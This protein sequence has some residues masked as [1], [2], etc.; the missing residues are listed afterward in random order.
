MIDK[1]DQESEEYLKWRQGS[2][3][4][5]E[6]Q[7]VIEPEQVVEELPEPKR[8]KIF[9]MDWFFGVETHMGQMKMMY[10]SFT[11]FFY[12]LFC[13]FMAYAIER[14][15]KPEFNILEI[16]YLFLLAIPVAIMLPF[17]LL[18]M[19]FTLSGG[20]FIGMFV[21]I[22]S[23]LFGIGGK[24]LYRMFGFD[25]HLL[26]PEFV[27]KKGE[28]TKRSILGKR[29]AYPFTA[30]IRDM[31]L[32]GES[33]LYNNNFSVRSDDELKVGME[34]E[35]IKHE[36]R[37]ITSWIKNHP[38]FLVREIDEKIMLNKEKM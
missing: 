33:L 13:V 38:T 5:E 4:V 12:Y 6:P 2:V 30:T 26:F 27:G 15:D 35:I 37:S 19:G 31:G 11:F 23:W 10:Y 8:S 1:I 29:S 21:G 3:P 9:F 34:I 14:I 20:I 22:F 16:L 24:F 32:P 36:N 28:I 25:M 17:V 18:F 7:E